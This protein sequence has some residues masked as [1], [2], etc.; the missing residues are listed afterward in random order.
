MN[1]KTAVDRSGVVGILLAAGSSRRFGINKL[2]QPLASGELMGMAAA[3]NLVTA[4]ADSL[5]VV[6]PGEQYLA[7]R[8]A[9]LGLRVVESPEAG[10]GM[11]LSLAAGITAAADAAGWL[12]ALAD[13]PWVQ[14]GTIVSLANE[15]RKGSSLVAP[16]HCGCRGHPVGFS[17]KWG[18]QLKALTGDVGARALLAGHSSELTLHETGDPGVLLDVD[19]QM[20]LKNGVPARS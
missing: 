5:V 16:V 2:L 7:E 4:V 10:Q 15:L 9:A 20:D 19:R 12:V 8:Y 13:M 1:L 6:R 3:R 18:R 11:G 17:S 14:P